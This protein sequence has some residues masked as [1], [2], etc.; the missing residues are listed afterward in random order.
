M[1]KLNQIVSLVKTFIDFNKELIIQ[2]LSGSVHFK[3]Q[4]IVDFATDLGE[5]SRKLVYNDADG[6][7]NTYDLETTEEQHFE[8]I[9]LTPALNNSLK[10]IFGISDNQLVYIQITL[11]KIAVETSCLSYNWENIVVLDQER[12]LLW[13]DKKL[14]LVHLSKEIWSFVPESEMKIRNVPGALGNFIWIALSGNGDKR[15]TTKLVALDLDTGTL[16]ITVAENLTLNPWRI[17]L[18]KDKKMIVSFS[19]KISAHEK[20]E[21]SFVEIDALTGKVI[22]DKYSSSLFDKNLK[23]EQWL[24]FNEMIYFSA[25]SDTI[26]STHIG[27]LNYVTLE[28]EW[29]TELKERIAG[30]QTIRVTESRFYALDQGK[31]L[32]VYEKTN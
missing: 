13:T 1:Y 3:G 10:T 5:V 2:D 7:A 23:L 32:H 15:Y 26:N 14:V 24:Y 19:G 22:R 28:L 12:Q 18:L 27:V 4:K 16:K 6:W 29:L 20:A 9:S 8:G 25:A 21:S 30:I 31:Q 17:A 11:E